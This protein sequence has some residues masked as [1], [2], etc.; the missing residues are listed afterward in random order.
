MTS[1]TLLHRRLRLLTRQTRQIS[2]RH[3]RRPHRPLGIARL[4]GQLHDRTQLLGA[5]RPGMRR[6]RD[7]GQRLERA[8]GL[9]LLPHRPRRLTIQTHRHV[10]PAPLIQHPHDREIL[11]VDAPL[12][13]NQVFVVRDQASR[14]PRPKFV[15]MIRDV[16][17][18]PIKTWG[19]D[20]YRLP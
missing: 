6:R 4:V 10:D 16:E 7:R 2:R 17:H 1:P 3:I 9:D 12:L 20:T 18:A 19:Y 15:E 11:E 14:G 13:A 5:Q 8:R